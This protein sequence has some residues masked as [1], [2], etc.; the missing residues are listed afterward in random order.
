MRTLTRPSNEGR[1]VPQ[2]VV[3]G[4]YRIKERS[5]ELK[6]IEIYMHL[7]AIFAVSTVF[8]SAFKELKG[9]WVFVI[10]SMIAMV[11]AFSYAVWSLIMIARG[12]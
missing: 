5:K 3:G 6:T 9:R 1:V 10:T 8:V 12:M 7:I 11:I 4:R 2:A